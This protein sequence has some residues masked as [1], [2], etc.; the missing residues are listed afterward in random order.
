MAEKFI[1]IEEKPAIAAEELQ[2]YKNFEQILKE[3]NRLV[4]KPNSG[5]NWKSGII[6]VIVLIGIYSLSEFFFNEPPQSETTTMILTD[7]INSELT[8][9]DSIARL[10]R[11][12]SSFRVNDDPEKAETVD[13][14]KP[15]D[16]EQDKIKFKQGEAKT[17]NESSANT[18]EELSE[19]SSSDTLA[20]SGFQRAFPTNG[21][22]NLYQYFND[23]LRYPLQHFTDSIEGVVVVGFAIDKDGAIIDTQVLESLGEEF[24]QEALRVIRGMPEWT[25]AKL[26]GQPVRSKLSIP[27]R[28]TIE[29]FPSDS[30]K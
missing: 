29:I 21:I 15:D 9:E 6:V 25:P 24:D 8:I 12:D 2:S 17:D 4:D 16:V 10:A 5:F 7:S 1:I 3:R 27:L 28:F 11:E 20:F 26:D 14:F 22:P 30:I 18:D 19:E 13:M 23:S